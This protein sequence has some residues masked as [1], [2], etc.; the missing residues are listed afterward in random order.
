[1]G[2]GREEYHAVS[3]AT[4]GAGKAVRLNGRAWRSVATG[5]DHDIHAIWGA[6]ARDVWAVAV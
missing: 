6:N 2:M 5:V 1:M 4:S 3:V